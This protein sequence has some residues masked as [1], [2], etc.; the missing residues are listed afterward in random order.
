[1]LVGVGVR[2]NQDINKD[3]DDINVELNTYL[4]TSE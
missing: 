2:P 1:M 3:K 4:C